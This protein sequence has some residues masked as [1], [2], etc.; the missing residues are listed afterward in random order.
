MT[1]PTPKSFVQR[2]I[3]ALD[4]IDQM[5]SDGEGEATLLSLAPE[6]VVDR[7]RKYV[8]QARAVR[9]GMKAYATSSTEEE[10]REP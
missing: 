1:D 8:K 9:D 3:D 2:M 6:I 10:A 4:Q 7:V 5:I